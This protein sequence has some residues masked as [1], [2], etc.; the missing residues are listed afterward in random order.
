MHRVERRTPHAI[1]HQFNQY[2]SLE[3]AITQ[4]CRP[5]RYPGIDLW[6]ASSNGI[7]GTRSYL[8]AIVLLFFSICFA[9]CLGPDVGAKLV[10]EFVS[11]MVFQSMQDVY[12]RCCT[13]H[14]NLLVTADSAGCGS[15]SWSVQLFCIP[16]SAR[17]PP[18]QWSVVWTG[19]VSRHLL[20][21]WRV[22]RLV[23]YWRPG[24]F[25]APIP[26]RC[27]HPYDQTCVPANWAK[28]MGQCCTSRASRS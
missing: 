1:W 16:E 20:C 25:F 12:P 22:V 21:R 15:G 23:L 27:Q 9:G 10:S 8:V 3:Q 2:T 7:G 14:L 28:L 24:C 26:D 4:D 19:I 5:N 13:M 17:G 18:S 11:S 6:L